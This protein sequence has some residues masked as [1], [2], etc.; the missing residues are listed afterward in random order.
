MARP[1][2][3][4][5]LKIIAAI[6]EPA[7]I[8]RIL[9]HLGLSAQPPPR[10]PVRRKTAIEGITGSLAYELAAFNVHVKL[11]EP[12]DGPTTRFTSNVGSRMEGLF[13]EA[14]ADFAKPL[15]AAFAKVTTES[16]VA[17]AV[18]RAANDG[19]GQLRFRA[20]ADAVALTQ[21]AWSGSAAPAAPRGPAAYV[22]S[23]RGFTCSD[24]VSSPTPTCARIAAVKY[25]AYGRRT[26]PRRPERISTTSLQ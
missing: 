4:A 25:S 20:G 17:E 5:N 11:V 21:S 3:G 24:G 7:V 12:G 8:E 10:A 19:S 14:Y 18:Y 1:R 23:A 9:T 22:R 26:T 13:P 15:L 6:E 2:C 16:D